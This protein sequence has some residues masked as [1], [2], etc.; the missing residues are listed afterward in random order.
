MGTY[1]ET[2]IEEAWFGTKAEKLRTYILNNSLE[3]G[4][5]GCKEQIEAGNFQGSKIIP[6]DKYA[7]KTD[8]LKQFFKQKEN[9]VEWPKVFEF[10]ISNICNLEC[11]MCNGYFSS[12]IR[13]NK[14]KLPKLHYPYDAQFIHQLRPF[15]PHL[16]DAK[17]LGGEPFLI[18]LYYKIWDEIIENKWK[19]RVHITTNGTVL[20]PKAKKYLDKMNAGITISVDSLEKEKLESIRKN[21][22]YDDFMENLEWLK[23]YCNR[24]KTYLLFAV[25]PMINNAFELSKI[26]TYC[27][28]NKIRIHFNTVWHPETVSLRHANENMLNRLIDDLESIPF[29]TNDKIILHNKQK[30]IDLIQHLKFWKIQAKEKETKYSEILHHIE[31]LATEN[32]QDIF[33]FL[34]AFH[35]VDNTNEKAPKSWSEFLKETGK[36]LKQIHAEWGTHLFLEVYFNGLTLLAEKTA[37]KSNDSELITKIRKLKTGIQ[38]KGSEEEVVKILLTKIHFFDCFLFIAENPIDHIKSLSEKDL[39]QTNF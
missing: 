22:N 29:E 10:E 1:P 6:Y 18:D 30:T 3:G 37:E 21:L 23:E 33:V 15:L 17:F 25:C 32:T 35:S 36:N 9:N 34:S 24:K 31:A 7:G 20:T 38:D 26:V 11:I 27:N 5:S 14:E 12:A 28:K 8:I 19:V 13:K 16:T 2:S 4:C 39:N